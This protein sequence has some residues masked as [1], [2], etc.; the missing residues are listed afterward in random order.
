MF[1]RVPAVA[2]EEPP[3]IRPSPQLSSMKRVTEDRSVRVLSTKLRLEKG[4][5]TR[6]GWRGPNP[7]L[8]FWAPCFGVPQ[9]PGPSNASAAVLDGETMG[10]ITWSYQPS[11]SS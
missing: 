5:I 8:P 1:S 2:S 11:E 7:H 10:P 9:L 3:P 6:N 4:E